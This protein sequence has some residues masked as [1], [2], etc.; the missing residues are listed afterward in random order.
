MQEVNIAFL[1]LVWMLYTLIML[2]ILKPEITLTHFWKFRNN[3]KK[4]VWSEFYLESCTS[5]L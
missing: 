2:R 1:S 5:L 4:I 3:H